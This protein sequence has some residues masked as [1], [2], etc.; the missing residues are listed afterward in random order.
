MKD[1]AQIDFH[2]H[3]SVVKDFENALDRE[4]ERVAD[5]MVA[6]YNAREI[7]RSLGVTRPQFLQTKQAVQDKAVEYLR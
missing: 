7:M 3:S 6:G 1:F 4:E 2:S 5:A